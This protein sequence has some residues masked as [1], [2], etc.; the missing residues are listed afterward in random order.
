MNSV[1]L[2]GRLV[3]EPELRFIAGSGT[4]VTKFTLAVDKGLSKAKK[5]ELKGAGKPTADFIRVVV[6]GKS[7]EVAADYLDKGSKVAVKGSIETGSYKDKDGK[8]VYTTEVRA[9]S[10][11]GIEFLEGR[12]ENERK[13]EFGMKAKDFKDD[14]SEVDDEDI[15][16]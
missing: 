13:D 6:W 10:Y 9:D 12:S 2:I 5:E 3:K 15:P 11:G 8:T 1:V 7:A 14:F 16:F 4:A